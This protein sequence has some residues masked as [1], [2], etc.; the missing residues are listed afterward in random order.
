MSVEDGAGAFEDFNTL[1]LVG[2]EFAGE[3][4]EAHAVAEDAEGFGGEAADLEPVESGLE[5]ILVGLDAGS[6]AEGLVHGDD[7]AGFHLAGVDDGDGLGYLDEKGSGFGAGVGGEGD[8]AGV[9]GDVD[10]VSGGAGGEGDVDVFCGRGDGD[11]LEVIAEAGSEDGEVIGA[12]VKA[13]GGGAVSG[14]LGVDDGVAAAEVDGGSL[15]DGGRG[16]FDGDGDGKEG[17]GGFD[18]AGG[19]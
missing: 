14:G 13:K 15:D 7:A 8:K 11:G 10:D 5:A 18:G 6:V 2:V 9:G 17:V 3:G 16:V 12:R 19:V 4:V 1:E